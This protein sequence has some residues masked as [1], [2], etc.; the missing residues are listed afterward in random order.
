M[1]KYT[2][3]EMFHT[4]QGEGAWQGTPATFIRLQGCNVGCSWCDTKST[5]GKGEGS[6]KLTAD[7]IVDKGIYHKHVVIT[8]GEPTLYNLAPLVTALRRNNPLA[9]VQLET[10]GQNKVTDGAGFSWITCSP[11]SVLGF[12]IHPELRPFVN[13]LKFVVDKDLTVANVQKVLGVVN[14]EFPGLM[15]LSF[16]P[17]GEPPNEESATRA[18][19]FANVFQDHFWRVMYADR[20]QYRLGVK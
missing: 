19:H 12:V 8:G 10:S 7:Q 18:M 17:E 4:I 5:W 20:L 2:L 9:Y 1:I 16:M 15:C 14:D 6:E 3:N 11:K 13:E